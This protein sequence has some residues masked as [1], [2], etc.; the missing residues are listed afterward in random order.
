MRAQRTPGP[1][2]QR[3]GSPA[4]TLLPGMTS[5]VMQRKFV[6]AVAREKG[7]TIVG[8]DA[9][10]VRRQRCGTGFCFRL[11]S[12]AVLRD[13]E[14]I[15][16]LKALAVPPAYVDVR[17]RRGSVGASPGR[18]HRRRRPAA[19]PLP[20]EMDRGARGAED[21]AT[22]RARQVAAR[23]RARRREGAAGGGGRRRLRGGGGGA[24]WSAGRRSA[25]AAR[26]MPA[27]TARAAPPPCS[28]R[29]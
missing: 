19:I 6:E 2:L 29:T 21:A 26:P 8:P 18:R 15:A 3:N 17:Y 1:E 5:Q 10:T 27:S 16:R 11:A 9:L 13:R 4:A 28:S 25:P 22:G 7:L 24:A 20:S 23:Y 12:G 14:E